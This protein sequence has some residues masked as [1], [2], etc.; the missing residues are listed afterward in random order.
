MNSYWMKVCHS[1]GSI[2]HNDQRQY[3]YEVNFASTDVVKQQSIKRPV[4]AI[5]VSRTHGGTRTKHT[6]ERPMLANTTKKTK[7]Q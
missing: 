4:V 6:L 2:H 7:L 5:T 3:L 1:F